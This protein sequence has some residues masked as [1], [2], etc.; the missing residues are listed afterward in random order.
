MTGTLRENADFGHLLQ[1]ARTAYQVLGWVEADFVHV[2]N[3]DDVRPVL[4]IFQTGSQIIVDMNLRI[5][6]SPTRIDR[7]FDRRPDVTDGFDIHKP[8]SRNSAQPTVFRGLYT[9]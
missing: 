2:E 5:D 9:K 8:S 1:A 4:N 6:F 7:V 3:H